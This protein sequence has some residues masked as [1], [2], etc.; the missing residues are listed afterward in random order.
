MS[1]SNQYL[2]E[3]SEQNQS[4]I[5]SLLESKEKNSKEKEKKFFEIFHKKE[6]ISN[7]KEKHLESEENQI[8][9]FKCFYCQNLYNNI[10]RFEAHMRLHVSYNK[11]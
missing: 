3:E 9:Q 4:F 5:Y 1:K 11:F 7:N 6:E 8:N 10:N 2:Q